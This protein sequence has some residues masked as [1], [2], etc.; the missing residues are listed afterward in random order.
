MK[1]KIK[2]PA[3][4]AFIKYWGQRDKNLILPYNDSFSMNLSSCYTLLEVEYFSSKDYRLWIRNYQ[5]KNYQPADKKLMEKIIKYYQKTKVFLSA[6]NDFGF[7]IYSKNSF[8]I[9]AGIASSASFYSALAVAFAYG[10]LKK[11]PN[12]KTLSLLARLSGSGSACRSIPDGFCWWRK[13]NNSLSSYAYSLASTT[14]WD[15]V[16]MV[17]IL[18]K[19]EKSTASA[20]GHL[21]AETSPFFFNRIKEVKKRL[22]KIKKAFFEKDFDTFGQLL[23]EETLSM[24]LVMMTQKPPLYYWSGKTIEVIKKIVNLRIRGKR[25]YYTIDAGENIHLICQRKDER[26]I[27]DYFIKQKEVESIIINYPAQGTRIIE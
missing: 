17:L 22:K 1:I 6:K 19:K 25:C 15:L 18:N 9:K 13:G 2:S 24:H 16:D 4:I 21:L 10:F 14:F 12:K 20:A 11:L 7:E 26:E 3:N 23:E 27:Y 5:E 8:P